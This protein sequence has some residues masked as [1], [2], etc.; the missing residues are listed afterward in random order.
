[1]AHLNEEDREDLVAYLDGEL[2]G[3]KAQELEAKL[4][5]DPNVRAEAEALRRTWQLL[6]Y[7]PRPEPSPSF[8]HRTLERVSSQRLRLALPPQRGRWR[9]WALGLGWAAAVL[10]AAGVGFAGVRLLTRPAPEPADAE[11]QL[12][13][14]LR[15]IENRRLYEHADDLRFL[16]ELDQPDLFGDDD[17]GS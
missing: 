16:R 11:E 2:D 10:I 14:D 4:N 13:R 1:M 6:D 8:T 9:P 7:L 3:Q 17:L 5:L 12:V 15:V